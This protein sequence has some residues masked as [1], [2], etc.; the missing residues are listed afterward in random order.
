MLSFK[1]GLHAIALR[2]LELV[3]AGVVES[4]IPA[5]AT[6][7]KGVPHEV[8]IRA[9]L[10]SAEGGYE[11]PYQSGVR[12]APPWLEIMDRLA[13]SAYTRYRSFIYD[14][15]MFLRYFEQ[16][17]P[18]LE[19]DWLNIGSR[20]ARRLTGYIIEELREINW[21]FDWIHIL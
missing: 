20:P 9:P 7:N 4:S 17:T 1:Y 6:H 11:R 13:A 12:D 3:V 10:R 19:L 15:R 18:I 2:N 21:F 5:E 16:A 8:F 14:D